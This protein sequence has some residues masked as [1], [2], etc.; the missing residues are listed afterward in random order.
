ML[1]FLFLLFFSVSVFSNEISFHELKYKVEFGTC[2]KKTTGD[3][4]LKILDKFRISKSLLEAKKYILDKDLESKFFLSSY[5][6]KFNPVSNEL[7]LSFNCPEPL[8]RLQV[9]NEN[10]TESYFSVLSKNGKKVDPNYENALRAEKILTAPLPVLS[11]NKS[12]INKQRLIDISRYL[13]KIDK[14]LVRRI[15]D[16]IID[17][18]DRLIIIIRNPNH[19]IT[20]FVGQDDWKNKSKRLLKSI[21]YFDQKKKY[22]QYVRFLNSKKIVVKFS[23]RL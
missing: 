2:P 11:M 1:K 18:N 13:E 17:E 5:D 22:P 4:T 14:K 10:G 3:L 15:S 16:L 23:H 12:Q 8:A 21:E 9:Y 6:I 20:A 7:D 19:A